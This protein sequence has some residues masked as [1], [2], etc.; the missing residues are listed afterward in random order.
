MSRKHSSKYLIQEGSDN[1]E[2]FS[3]NDEIILTQ[4][5]ECGHLTLPTNLIT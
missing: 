5:K 2:L 4:F 1:P 3:D